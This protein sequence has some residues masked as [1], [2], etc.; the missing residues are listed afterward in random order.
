VTLTGAQLRLASAMPEAELQEQVRL[1]CAALHLAAQHVYDSRRCWL[2]G[3]PD[4]WIAGP[5][6]ILYRELK[7]EG[8]G[9]TPDQRRVGRVITRAGGDW[10]MWLPSD[11]LDGTVDAELRAI[12]AP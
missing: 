4:L 1:R 11:L 8:G 10:A 9:P 7:R 2:P 12:A 6:G 5:G 3:W